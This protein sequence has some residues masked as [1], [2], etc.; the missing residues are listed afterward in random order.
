MLK[1]HCVFGRIFWI[2]PI[3][4]AFAGIFFKYTQFFYCICIYPCDII[5]IQGGFLSYIF[6]MTGLLIVYGFSKQN[7]SKILLK[8]T[9]FSEKKVKKASKLDLIVKVVLKGLTGIIKQYNF[10][11]EKRFEGI[12][13]QSTAAIFNDKFGFFYLRFHLEIKTVHLLCPGINDIAD[14]LNIKGNSGQW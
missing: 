4:A 9:L 13:L 12:L 11:F 8:N 6:D 14:F 10:A 1:F 7:I 2:C 5:K 3:S